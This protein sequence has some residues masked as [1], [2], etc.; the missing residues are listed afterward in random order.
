MLQQRLRKLISDRLLRPMYYKMYRARYRFFDPSEK[1]IEIQISEIKSWYRGNRYEQFTFPGQ[2]KGGDWSVNITPKE[3]ILNTWEKYDGIMQRYRE[4][5]PWKD[6]DLFKNTYQKKL[7]EGIR[8]HGCDN[9]ADLEKFYEHRYDNLFAKIRDQGILP[10]SDRYPGIEPI[11]VHIDHNGEIL[12]TVD[13]NHR[14]CMCMILEIEKIP[15]RVWMRHKG[16]QEKREHI[17]ARN[18]KGV[19]IE[20]EPFLAHPDIVTELRT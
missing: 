14:L 10:A 20:Y 1:T 12:Y 18:G 4:E 5:L 2:I 15:V 17:L 7:Q 11:Y 3:E 13:G 19:G 9:L 8:V 6:T 16:W